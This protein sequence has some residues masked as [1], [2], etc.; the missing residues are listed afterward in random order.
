MTKLPNIFFKSQDPSGFAL[1]YSVNEIMSNASSTDKG[2]ARNV[3]IVLTKMF[4]PFVFINKFY[5]HYITII[6]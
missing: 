4:G 5:L 3:I 6:P 1:H 2:Q